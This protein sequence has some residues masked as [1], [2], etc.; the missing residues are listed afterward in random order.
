MRE[1]PKL[2]IDERNLSL[3]QGPTTV[4]LSAQDCNVSLK[5]LSLTMDAV[6]P[7]LPVLMD[8]FI[9]SV[10]DAPP[11]SELEGRLGLQLSYLYGYCADTK[12]PTLVDGLHFENRQFHTD[13]LTGQT[14]AASGLLCWHRLVRRELVEGKRQLTDENSLCMANAGDYDGDIVRVLAH[15]QP[16]QA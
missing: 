16:L 15:F 9:S 13:A 11:D 7:P 5:D 12:C 8:S 10:L 14:V 1:A 3:R 4:L 2:V 6:I